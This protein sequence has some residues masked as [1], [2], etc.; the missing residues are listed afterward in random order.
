L[1]YA[2]LLVVFSQGYYVWK[3]PHLSGAGDNGD[4]SRK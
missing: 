1:D 4:S 2:P 3:R